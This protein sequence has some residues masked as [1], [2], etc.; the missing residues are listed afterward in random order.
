[1]VG[2]YKITNLTT[3]ECYV[4]KSVNIEK[5]WIDHFSKSYGARHS[6]RF[7]EAIDKYG[8]QGFDFRVIEECRKV[9]ILSNLLC[10]FEDFLYF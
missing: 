8:K 5:R 6:V 1:M 7:Q 4:G 9:M 2:I 10:G 3:N